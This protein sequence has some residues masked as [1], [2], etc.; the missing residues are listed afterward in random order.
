[1][2]SVGCGFLGRKPGSPG[3]GGHCREADSPA[4]PPSPTGIGVAP[5]GIVG[6]LLAVQM[7]Q[8]VEVFGF[9]AEALKGAAGKE[10]SA[11]A[12][13]YSQSRAGMGVFDVG[14]GR[15]PELDAE[16]L[17]IDAAI[18]ELLEIAG[19]LRIRS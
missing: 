5:P 13:Y 10:A 16:M 18:V 9:D 15:A 14:N 1:M 19:F 6:T 3:G 11:P 12:Y 8:Q 2:L 17:P 4:P 7:C